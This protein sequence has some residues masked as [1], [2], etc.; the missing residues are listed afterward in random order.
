MAP[1]KAPV[2]DSDLL[3]S[4]KPVTLGRSD[5]ERSAERALL[6]WCHDLIDSRLVKDTRGTVSA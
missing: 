2:D 1:R 4:G 3:F 6:E 5:S